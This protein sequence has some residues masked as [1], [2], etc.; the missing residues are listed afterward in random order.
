MLQSD[1][2]PSQP[3]SQ[4]SSGNG[5]N[6]SRHQDM[7]DWGFI[8]QCLENDPSL[9][10]Q[11]LVNIMTATSVNGHLQNYVRHTVENVL[12]HQGR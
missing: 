6:D 2:P 9:T 8:N 5:R 3:P 12:Q 10:Y 7:R 1:E 4:G 11:D